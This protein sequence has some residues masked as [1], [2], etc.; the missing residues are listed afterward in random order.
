MEIR[1]ALPAEMAALNELILRE[2]NEA[3]A[4]L[5]RLVDRMPV[6]VAVTIVCRAYLAVAA[7]I[8]ATACSNTG[9]PFD[10][11]LLVEMLR[12]IAASKPIDLAT[13]NAAQESLNA[14]LRSAIN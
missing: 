14:R 9:T 1:K 13:A 2:N 4:D 11:Q 12:S 7:S 5:L 3:F 10:P 6:N 8:Y